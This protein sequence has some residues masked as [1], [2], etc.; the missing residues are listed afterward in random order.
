M[1]IQI[2]E[3]RSIFREP[4][5]RKFGATRRSLHQELT[6]RALPTM[7]LNVSAEHQVDN[8]YGTPPYPLIGVD[9]VYLII[10]ENHVPRDGKISQD[11]VNFS[12]TSD[13]LH[14]GGAICGNR[15]LMGTTMSKANAKED[16][17]NSNRRGQWTLDEDRYNNLDS[18]FL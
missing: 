8:M 13:G 14:Y 10:G 2:G 3:E 4:V 12:G 15:A 9:D 17:T 18:M 16:A 5:A 1:A 7:D 11:V 6:S